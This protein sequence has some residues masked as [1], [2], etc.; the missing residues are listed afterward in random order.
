MI[1]PK[2]S[3]PDDV[4]GELSFNTTSYGWGNWTLYQQH[5]P[6][7]A[8]KAFRSVVTGEAWNAWGFIGSEVELE[9]MKN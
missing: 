7:G 3:R 5:D 6:A 2:P 9:R 1:P 8:A 4:E